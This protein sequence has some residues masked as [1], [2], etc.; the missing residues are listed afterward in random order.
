MKKIQKIGML[1]LLVC[2]ML[3]KNMIAQTMVGNWKKTAQVLVLANGQKTDS[4][5]MLCKSQPCYANIVYSFMSDGNMREDASGCSDEI[6][7]IVAT[8][9]PKGSWKMRNNIVT[10]TTSDNSIPPAKYQIDFSG[11]TMTWNF[12]YDDNPSIPNFKGRS[13]SMQIVYKKIK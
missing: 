7:K 8:T 3:Q 10:I 1:F 2:C 4:Y 9:V 6:K 13:K 12:N 11:D 5:K